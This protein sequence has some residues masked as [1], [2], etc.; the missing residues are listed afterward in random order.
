VWVG[1]S[2]FLAVVVFGT[3]IQTLTNNDDPQVEPRAV[4]RRPGDQGL[5]GA[6]IAVGDKRL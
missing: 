5:V 2:T 1:A 4:L 6:Y 3:L